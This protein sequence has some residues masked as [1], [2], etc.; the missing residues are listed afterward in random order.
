MLLRVAQIANYKQSTNLDVKNNNKT[1]SLKLG[2][3]LANHWRKK[4]YF[5]PYLQECY[6]FTLQGLHTQLTGQQAELERHKAEVSSA[7]NQET[8][9][10]LKDLEAAKSQLASK[11]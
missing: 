3:V 4:Y 2:D 6:F 8:Q 9:N 1:A 11:G 10:V 7:F 5:C